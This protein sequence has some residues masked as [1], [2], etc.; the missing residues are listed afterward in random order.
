MH[1]CPLEAF[2]HDGQ[3][4]DIPGIVS[5]GYPQ[6]YL[7]AISVYV[8]VAIVK[9]ELSLKTSMYEILQV[10]GITLFEKTP[11]KTVFSPNLHNFTQGDS[12][13]QLLLFDL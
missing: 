6:H 13:N 12:Y 9:K 11:I 4:D 3:H 7:L 10:L 1:S 2:C 5:K 8:L